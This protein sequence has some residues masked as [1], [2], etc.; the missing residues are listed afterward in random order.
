MLKISFWLQKPNEK[1]G[2]LEYIQ[3]P[4]EKQGSLEYITIDNPKVNKVREFGW[5]SHGCDVYIYPTIY[6]TNPVE[7]LFIASEIIKIHLQGLITAGYSISEVESREPWKL[8][9]LSDNFLEEKINEIKSNPNMS[10]ED[11]D[12]VLGI[13]K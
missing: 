8:E 9:K 5:N 11:K 3:K 6:G 2:S 1:Q 12:K 13:L 10:Q 4:N 7:P